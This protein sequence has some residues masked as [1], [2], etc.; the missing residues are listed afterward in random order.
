MNP[1][2]WFAALFLAIPAL[3]LGWWFLRMETKLR[4]VMSTGS[5]SG[6]Y[7]QLATELGNAFE[8]HRPS[9][10]WT[11]Q[12]SAGSA[13]N[14]ARLESGVTDVAIVQNDAIANAA[15]RSLAMLYTESLHLVCRREAKITCLNDLAKHKTNLGSKDGGTFQLV[16][17]LLSF[18]RI[19]LPADNLD[20][21]GFQDAEIGL[22]SGELDA[23]FFLVGVGA[24]VIGRLLSDDRFELVPIHIQV[25]SDVDS[26]VSEEAFIDGFRT[27]YPY[28]TYTDI[29]LM[30]YEGK[31]RRPIAAVGI[32]A[33]LACRGDW[34]DELARDLVQTLFAHKAV[35]GHQIPLLSGLDETS[36]RSSL[37][38]PLHQGAESYYRRNEPGFLAE[39]AESIGLLITLALLTFS[40]LH[41]V[42]KWIDQNRKNRV[43]VYYQRVQE[44]QTNAN[45]SA[46]NVDQAS[47]YRTLN[48]IES[49]AC[50][51][52]IS[53]RLDA[54]H[55]YVILQNMIARCRR[56]LKRIHENA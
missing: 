51:E 4:V 53:E 34:D 9:V 56:E 27:H 11:L 10:E 40:G 6:V 48:E 21:L 43:D 26:V 49:Q 45:L 17:E 55:S 16:R 35:L 1:K 14:V 36:S 25:G 23:A 50:E 12:S 33:V 18:S 7:H 41:G 54:D 30:A 3:G 22:E 5:E 2:I 52:L 20:H 37:Q 44:L 8:N 15:V 24:E 28:A 46:G 38:F 29:P 31:P 13:E 39:N 47:W 19:E 32:A 42:K